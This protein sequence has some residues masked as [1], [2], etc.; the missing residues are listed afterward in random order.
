MINQSFLDNLQPTK[1]FA[2]Y[3]KFGAKRHDIYLK[4]LKRESPPWTDDPIFREYKFT[5]IFRATD[6]VSQYC[7][8]DVIYEGGSMDPE[9]VVFRILLFKLINTITAWEILTTAL[10]PLT[11][12][13]FNAAT[14]G[15]ILD[16]A[17][18]AGVKIWGNAYTQKP[19][20]RED[21]VGKHNR[22][23]ALLE[24][25][26]SGITNKLLSAQTYEQACDSLRVPPIIGD[27]TAMQ[28]ACDLNYSPVLNFGE[29]DFIIAGPGCLKGIRKCFG[30]PSVFVP[31]AQAIIYHCVE[32]QEVYFEGLGYEPVT[33]FG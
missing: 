3:W 14:Y 8:K 29:D 12:Q 32:E 2:T 25:M 1:V 17:K 20:Y 13:N 31:E 23:L 5:N 22:Y 33:L 16:K 19:Q 15:E 18:A 24:D 27:F 7:I 30:L 9:E 6:R 11:W 28:L 4:R 21:L 26:R 10:G